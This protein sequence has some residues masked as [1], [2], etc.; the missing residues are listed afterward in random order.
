[1]KKRTDGLTDFSNDG[2]L[3]IINRLVFHPRGYALTF[4]LEADGTVSSYYLQ[5]DGKEVWQ[6]TE[7]DD[8][9]NFERFNRF[10]KEATD[11]TR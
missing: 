6:F 3:W 11:E 10:L 7:A 5:G 1:M 2:L 9:K 4:D 8:D